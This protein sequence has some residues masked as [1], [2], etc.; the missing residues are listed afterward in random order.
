MSRRDYQ[1]ARQYIQK[2]QHKQ[3]RK[4]RVTTEL[5]N[6]EYGRLIAQLRIF[7]SSRCPAPYLLLLALLGKIVWASELFFKAV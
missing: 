3:T 5:N 2:R 7:A 4:H 6:L 1:Y